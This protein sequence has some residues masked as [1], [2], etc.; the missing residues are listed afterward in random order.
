[1]ARRSR[2]QRGLA[3]EPLVL[4]VDGGGEVDLDPAQRRRK[5][6]AIGARVEPGAEVQHGVATT[7]DGL[8]DEI[9]DD[10]GAQDDD[11]RHPRTVDDAIGDVAAAPLDE[12]GGERIAEQRIGA[13]ALVGA[14]GGDPERGVGNMGDRRLAHGVPYHEPQLTLAVTIQPF[15]VG[16]QVPNVELREHERPLLHATHLNLEPAQT[17]QLCERGR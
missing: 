1:M 6:E 2:R 5:L 11:P 14:I 9:V 15:E 12:A 13:G 16:L 8:A 7:G 10:A 4:E 3:G 17:L